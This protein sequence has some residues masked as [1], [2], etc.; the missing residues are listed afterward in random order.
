[1]AKPEMTSNSPVSSDIWPPPSRRG[2]NSRKVGCELIEQRTA[3][4]IRDW[5]TYLK[6]IAA[7]ISDVAKMNSDSV[8][9]YPALASSVR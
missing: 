3:S 7:A 2:C 6:R 9:G 1:M 5:Q 4:K 8:C